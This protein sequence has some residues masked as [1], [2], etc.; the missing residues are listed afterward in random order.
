MKIKKNK[1]ENRKKK[2]NRKKKTNKRNCVQLCKPSDDL[3]V[4]FLYRM[5]KKH[6]SNLQECKNEERDTQF[7]TNEKSKV[8][9]V[10]EKRNV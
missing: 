7:E 3:S 9:V 6:I 8:Y 10:D 4:L 2:K 1:R 5:H